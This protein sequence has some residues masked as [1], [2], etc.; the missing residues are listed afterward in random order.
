MEIQQW[1]NR[2]CYVT[3]GLTA[4]VWCAGKAFMILK[5]N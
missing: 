5:G 4:G 1:V 2:L 3:E